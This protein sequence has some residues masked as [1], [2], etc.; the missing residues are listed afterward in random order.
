MRIMKR[1]WPIGLLAA[2]LAL[3]ALGNSTGATV[4]FVL[5]VLA[6][7]GFWFGVFKSGDNR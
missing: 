4:L 5:G 1:G 6:E 7:S 3:Y 2:A